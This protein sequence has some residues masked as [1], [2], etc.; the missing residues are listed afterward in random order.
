MD[1]AEQA[2]VLLTAGHKMFVN[3]AETEAVIAHVERL[4]REMGLTETRCAVTYEHLLVTL[5]QGSEF[6]TRLGSQLPGAAVNM[7]VVTQLERGLPE[8]SP[9]WPKPLV[10]LL[11]GMTAACLSHL[12]GGDGAAFAASW[13]AAS[14][15]M[16]V[17]QH[18]TN[19]FLTTFLAALV[20]GL[21]G[22]LA[23]RFSGTPELCLL[24]P[25][26]V[27]VPGVPL[28]NAVLDLAHNHV[29]LALARLAWS[30]VA[31]VC[32]SL[33]LGAAAWVT[34]ADL[35][36]ALATTTP[37]LPVVALLSAL[38]GLGYAALFGIPKELV[39]ACMACSCL[40]FTLRALLAPHT[41]LVLAT[42]LASFSVSCL[43]LLLARRWQAPPALFAYPGVVAM[44]PGAF[45]FRAVTGA[46]QWAQLGA[47]APPELLA[48]TGSLALNVFLLIGAIA[49]G[50]LGPALVRRPRASLYER[51]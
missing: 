38:C 5:I 24:A 43:A 28:V 27:I 42:G 10:V 15:A 36:V 25:A 22:G 21:I 48:L 14:V 1:L 37:A 3:G 26:M 31:L 20:S 8:G 9:P 12:F 30:C 39:P 33:G 19:P 51:L 40:G 32:I 29:T 44:I 2:A 17:R 4:G 47:E 34:Q 13:G 6:R 35:A 41:S 16:V 23:A 46:L 49:V 45:A 7:A 11:V 50:L 18:P